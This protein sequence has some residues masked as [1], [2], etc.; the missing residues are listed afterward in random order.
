MV[1]I[2]PFVVVNAGSSCRPG[3]DV[4]GDDRHMMTAVSNFFNQRAETC[5]DENAAERMA[6]SERLIRG[7]EISRGCKVLDV[8]CGTSL[9]I[10]WLL[11]AV[12]EEWSVTAINIAEWMSWIAHNKHER[13][14]VEYIRA[15]IAQTPFLDRS[16]Y[17]IVCHNC[18]PHVTNKEGVTREIHCFLKP[19][20]RVAICHDQS[21]VAVNALHRSIG[22]EVEGDML[23]DEPEMKESFAGTDFREISILDSGDWYLMQAYKPDR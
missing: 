1:V 19:G 7:L 5:D 12:G 23:P 2:L 3:S 17:E 21:R 22:G 4:G 8:G 9:I 15:D 20:G 10:H 13:P 6:V 11:E 18:F 16:F 14:N